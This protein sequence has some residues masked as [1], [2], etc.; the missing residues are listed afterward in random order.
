MWTTR[1]CKKI[2]KM[3]KKRKSTKTRK[4][5]MMDGRQATLGLREGVEP[6]LYLSTRGIVPTYI[7]CSLLLVDLGHGY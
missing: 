6:F 5:L 7:S 3:P 1:D 4:D 2:K